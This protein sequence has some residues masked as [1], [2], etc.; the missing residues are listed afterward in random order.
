MPPGSTTFRPAPPINRLTV[1]ESEINAKQTKE[2]ARSRENAPKK[3]L[4]AVNKDTEPA[5]PRDNIRI[6]VETP[7]EVPRQHVL[8]APQ[9]HQRS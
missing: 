2:P 8:V 9:G 7:K 3:A 5:Q 6:M 1:E 4:P